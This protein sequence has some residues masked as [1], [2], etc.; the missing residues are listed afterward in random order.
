[1]IRILTT[2]AA[3]AFALVTAS[4]CCTSDAKPPGLRALPKFQEIE[5]A[6]APEYAP[7]PIRATK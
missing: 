4:C 1:M 7:A 3:A 5:P 6:Q 2:F